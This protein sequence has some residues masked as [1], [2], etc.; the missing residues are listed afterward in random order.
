MGSRKR[1]FDVIHRDFFMRRCSNL[2]LALLRATKKIVL[3]ALPPI[4]ALSSVAVASVALASE[5]TLSAMQG[6]RRVL[7]VSSPDMKSALAAMQHRILSGWQRE[8]ADRE[9]TL[10]EVAGASVIGASDASMRLRKRYRSSR[11]VMRAIVA[12]VPGE[13]APVPRSSPAI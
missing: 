12:I 4:L 2:I 13:R 7:L 9:V 11:C 3:R 5:P 10:V 8:A 1:R 6:H